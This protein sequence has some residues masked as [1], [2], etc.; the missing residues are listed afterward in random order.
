MDSYLILAATLDL[1]KKANQKTLA[2]VG[3][4]LITVNPADGITY[5]ATLAKLK[6]QDANR[7]NSW[8]NEDPKVPTLADFK[9][10]LNELDIKEEPPVDE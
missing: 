8:T 6:T 4:Q 2:A 10:K 9:T 7:G 1:T 3:D 5:V